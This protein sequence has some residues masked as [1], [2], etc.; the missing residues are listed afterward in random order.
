MLY[1]YREFTFTSSSYAPEEKDGKIVDVVAPAD[2]TNDL[3]FKYYNPIEERREKNF[4][5]IRCSELL[6]KDA[7][8]WDVRDFRGKALI[9]RR[10]QGHFQ[11]GN[12]YYW[13]EGCVKDFDANTKKGIYTIKY[14][15]G[16]FQ[17]VNLTKLVPM[18]RRG[19]AH[20]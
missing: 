12:D 18:L 7:V 10:V 2:N 13:Y 15:D 16:E 20:Y 5:Y 17:T 8:T 11:L 4:K 14:C 9:G 19:K 1:L 3:H 6:K